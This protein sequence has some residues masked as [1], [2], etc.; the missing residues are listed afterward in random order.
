MYKL[1]EGTFATGDY[2]WSPALET[3]SEEVTQPDVMVEDTPN[4]GDTTFANI[5]GD[6]TVNDSYFENVSFTANVGDGNVGGSSKCV[7]KK[8]KRKTLDSSDPV[9]DGIY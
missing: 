2:A 7:S 1:F 3:L 4:V 6:D 9:L 8:G 5:L